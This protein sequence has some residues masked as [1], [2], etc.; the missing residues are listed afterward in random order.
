MTEVAN[1]PARWDGFFFWISP[2][3]SYFLPYWDI[4]LAMWD[5][6]SILDVS[7]MLDIC[8]GDQS[9]H[10]QRRLSKVPV[11]LRAARVEIQ[12]KA[13]R[14]HRSDPRFGWRLHWKKAVERCHVGHVTKS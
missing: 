2:K 13:D 14:N 1:I 12:E 8:P 4:H 3:S 6:T 5:E 9:S 10:V 7:K 11:A